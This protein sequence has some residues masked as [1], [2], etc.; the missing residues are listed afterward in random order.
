MG[1][2]RVDD[3]FYDHPK[4]HEVNALAVALWVTGLAWCNR[5]L[6][7]GFIPRSTAER[8]LNFDDIDVPVGNTGWKPADAYDAIEQLIG[9]GSW[10]AVERGFQIVNY[11]EFQP[12]AAE[13]KAKRAADLER[14]RGS[15]RIP[16]GIQTE[17]AQSP[18]RPNPNPK[19]IKS[20]ARPDGQASAF[21]EFWTAYPRHVGK[22][23]AARAWQTAT[24]ATSPEVII[25][26]A[27][28][29][30]AD[31]NLPAAQFIP[32]PTTWLTRA[33]WMDDPYPGENAPAV[34]EIRPRCP[35]HKHMSQPCATCAAE[36]AAGLR[37]DT[38]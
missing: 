15:E 30:R 26:G 1:W 7:D 6:T 16:R 17:S 3:S 37:G 29:L 38:A 2:V 10:E 33:G 35:E 11:L 32:H 24:K 13:V 36:R 20:V 4:F 21:D 12:S 28:R 23:K 9:N 8:L 22:A 27:R 25:E 31:P 5:T 19:R 18:D 34:R 14:K